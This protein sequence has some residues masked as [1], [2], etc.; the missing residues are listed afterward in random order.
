MTEVAGAFGEAARSLRVFRYHRKLRGEVLTL[1]EM[2]EQR[3]A[4]RG[5]EPGHDP[6][7]TP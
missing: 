4:A 6:A 3:V 5:Q 2:H 1:P 7:L